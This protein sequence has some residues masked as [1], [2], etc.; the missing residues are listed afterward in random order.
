MQLVSLDSD[1]EALHFLS[2]F[3]DNSPL[4]DQFTHLGGVASIP[5]TSTEW[6]WVENTKKVNFTLVFGNGLPDN[7]GGNEVCLTLGYT[8]NTF[9]FND[10]KCYESYIFKFVC[11]SILYEPASKL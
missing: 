5:K 1:A 11:Q 8:S 2:L 4:F 7:Y 10:L 9:Y 3:V 6:F